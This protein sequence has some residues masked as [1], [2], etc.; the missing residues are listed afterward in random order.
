MSEYNIYNTSGSKVYE[1]K[2]ATLESNKCPIWFVGHGLPD[3][4]EAQNT[5]FLRMLEHYCHTEE[6]NKPI[7]GQIWYKQLV[8]DGGNLNGKYELRVCRNPDAETLEERWDKL[9][10]LVVPNPGQTEPTD[11]QNGDIWYDFSTHSLKVY[12][13]NQWNLIGPE[14]SEHLKHMF[15]S[16]TI[17]QIDSTSRY[18]M[19][20]S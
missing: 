7:I 20:K 14:D 8:D 15:F 16:Q 11:V 9:P 12:D 4:G 3:Y 5:N 2:E 1:V 6:P 18:I 17:T 10:H 13:N 19:P